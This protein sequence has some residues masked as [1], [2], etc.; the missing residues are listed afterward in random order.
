MKTRETL[1]S[2]LLQTLVDEWGLDNVAAA[3]RHISV[4]QIHPLAEIPPITRH[5]PAGER[6]R[7]S[8]TEQIERAALDGEQKET[9]LELAIRFDRKQFLP[10]VAD[11]R[12][13][14][15]MMGERPTDLKD[16]KEA[17]R[18]LLRNLRQLPVDRLKQIASTALHSG[19]SQLGPISDAIAA[20]GEHLSRQRQSNSELTSK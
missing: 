7:P 17:F 4:P 2:R 20:A 11:I 16:R 19:P 13:F 15:T 9:L 6:A 12:E 14:L 18:I 3:L 8:A 1:L 10:S 5:R